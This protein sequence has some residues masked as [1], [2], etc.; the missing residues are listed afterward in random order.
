M[1]AWIMLAGLAVEALLGWPDALDRRIGHPV[2]WFGWLV[3][4]A[5]RL[6]NREAWSRSARVAMGGLV[7]MLLVALAGLIGLTIQLVLADGWVGF[8]L[9]ALL[10]SSLMAARSL[11]DHVADVASAFEGAGIEA[12][13]CTLG[14]IVG[15]ETAELDEV[16]I[17]RAAIESL[18]ENTSDGVTA[19]LFWGAL[20]GLPGLFAY[21]AINTLDS[22]IGHRNARYEAFG[23]VA[24]RLDDLANLIPARLTGTLFTLCAGS[25]WAMKVMFRDAREHR[26]PNA[27]WPESAMAGA[28]GIRL[29][30]P[31]TYGAATSEEPW[32]NADAGDPD[33]ADIRRALALY[34]RVVVAAALLLAALGWAH[35]P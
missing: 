28:L 2:R 17:A 12:A 34:R 23:K 7:T 13:R 22:M 9:M 5:E 15:R 14:R 33:A 6:G 16:A 21:K 11:H 3:E 24:A 20:L 25:G 35:L 32:L 26:S 1:A 19:P 31:R 30:G 10:A 29:S 18:A 27:G 4:R 8:V